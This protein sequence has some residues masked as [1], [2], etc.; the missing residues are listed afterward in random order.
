MTERAWTAPE[1]TPAVDAS[2][3]PARPTEDRRGVV[4]QA[5][6]EPPEAGTVPG[7]GSDR[8]EGR[9]RLGSTVAPAPDD[10][11]TEIEG[12]DRSSVG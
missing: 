4:D 2:D 10:G 3:D 9:S 1:M 8:I 11:E 5:P 7:I 12:E 6:V